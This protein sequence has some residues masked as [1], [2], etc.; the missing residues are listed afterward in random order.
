MRS[1]LRPKSQLGL[2]ADSRAVAGGEIHVVHADVAVDDLH[3][4]MASALKLMYDRV[5]RPQ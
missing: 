2:V 3:P 5:T 4:P 1:R